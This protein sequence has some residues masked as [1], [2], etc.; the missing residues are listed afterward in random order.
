MNKELS[1]NESKIKQIIETHIEKIFMEIWKPIENKIRAQIHDVDGTLNE[2]NLK[3]QSM[4]K[5]YT[6]IRTEFRTIKAHNE[7]YL[8][9]TRTELENIREDY[10]SIKKDTLYEVKDS[11]KLA[12]ELGQKAQELQLP[13]NEK[14]EGFSKEVKNITE[15][16]KGLIKNECDLR[17]IEILE[18][19]KK[20]EELLKLSDKT[21]RK[22][23]LYKNVEEP[24]KIIF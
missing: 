5:K 15:G 3:D 22:H 17:I 21:L 11:V 23:E 12:I 10:A 1:I 20:Y 2:I 16:A 8:Q 19:K 13:L 6:K 18:L 9:D 4:D 7:Q 24:T 14:I